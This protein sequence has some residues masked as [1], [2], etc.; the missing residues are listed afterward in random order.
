MSPEDFVA[1]VYAV[2]AHPGF[3]ERFWTQLETRQL[4][5]PLTKDRVLFGEA[6]E[7]GR[8]LLWL[9]T[10]GERFTSRD[11][12]RGRIPRGRSRCTRAVPAD[13]DQYP[14]AFDWLAGP[15]GDGTLIVGAGEFAPV[16]REVYE[17]EVSGL[18]V[19][20][21]WLNYRMRRPRNV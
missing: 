4:R 3:K 10:F 12:P 19:V 1:Y 14:D 8:R 11:R 5:A 6:V 9:H 16:A 2:L 21:S 15:R 7:I 18:R 13:P 17:F 20:Q